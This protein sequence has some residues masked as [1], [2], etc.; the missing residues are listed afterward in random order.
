MFGKQLNG[1]CQLTLLSVILIVTSAGFAAVEVKTEHMNPADS[2][3]NFKTIVG[4]SKSDIASDA[5]FWIVENQLA[6]QG[7]KPEALSD[8]ELPTN[9]DHLAEIVFL[10][11]DSPDKGKILIDLGQAQKVSAFCTYSWHEYAPDDGSRGPQVYTLYGSKDDADHADPAKW[12]KIA[13]VDTRPNTTGEKWNGQYG[14][15]IKGQLGSYRYLLMV[16]SPTASPKQ[17]NKQ[18]TQTLF[19]EIDVHTDE[20]LAKAGDAKALKLVKVTDVYVVFK[21]HLDIGYTH[22]VEDVIKKYRVD[23][24]DNALK[25]IES[26]RSLPKN[27]RFAWTLPGWAT[28]AILGPE[29]DPERKKRIE[30]AIKNGEIAFHALPATLYTESLDYEDLVRGLKYSVDVAK[31]YDIPVTIAGKMTDVP[32]H[33]WVLPTLLKHAGI[34]FMHIGCNYASSYPIL[35]KLFWWEG[36]DGSR[37]LTAYTTGY[38]SGIIPPADWPAKNYLA[39]AMTNDNTGPPS[40]AD[41]ENIR[42]QAARDLPGVNIHFGTLDDFA[43]A[44][45]KEQPELEVV[46]GDTPDTWAHGL[47]SMPIATKLIRNTRPLG[48]AL[49][50]IDTQLNAWGVETDSIAEKQE[51]AYEQS[52][53]YSEHTWGMNGAYGGRDIW[54][55]QEVKKT[56]S[57]HKLEHFLKSFDDH[58]AYAQQ[59]GTIWSHEVSQRLSLLADSVKADGNSMVVY[60]A[61]PWKRS[62][63]V[64]IPGQNGGQMF[65]KDIPA[66]GYKTVSLD[67][68][69][70]TEFS[71]KNTLETPF[72]TVKFDLDRGGISSLKYKKTGRELVDTNS[73]YALGQFMHE[74]FSADNVMDFLNSY[75]RWEAGFGED[76]FGK[77][78][79]PKDIKYAKIVPSDWTITTVKSDSRDIVTLT[80]G[81]TKGLAKAY[82][83]T[84]SFSRNEPSVE[85]KWTVDT[86]TPKKTP[87]GGWLCMPLALDAPEFTVGRSGGPI[88]PSKDIIPG[89][90]RNLLTVMSGVSVQGADGTGMGVCPL[91]SPLVSLGIPGLYQYSLDY[92]PTEPVVFVNL[93]NN[94]WNTNFPLWIEG[95]WSERVKI[96]PITNKNVTEDLAVKSWESRM[97]LLAAKATGNKGMLPKSRRGLSLSRKGVL[98]TA[99][100]KDP[101]G[102]EGTL[103]R[104]W[105]QAGKSGKITVTLPKGIKVSKATAVN[106]RGESTGK[107]I[108]VSGGKLKFN[109]GAYAPA[110]YILQ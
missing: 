35:P 55:L 56:L 83:L 64:D 94:E 110:S 74:R 15:V 48:P 98:V 12:T 14:A 31:E 25:I 37:V 44:V 39:M 57:K 77:R 96:W 8:G 32:E 66:C 78:G 95:S 24:M 109:L 6:T 61:L 11:N 51:T 107:T 84:F 108:K 99:F 3:W 16:I 100:G 86:N 9:T 80:T 54:D 70:E 30:E 71:D 79:M 90:G 92:I 19:A 85:V 29:Q 76:D 65:V 5:Q 21:T 52:L 89:S 106:L 47:K 63:L 102:E 53:L 75:I 38:G 33:S 34:E 41:V 103:L 104:V 26:G 68:Y 88:D 72:Y 42:K 69:N 49:D 20:T 18:W 4:P 17:A 7:A 36:P 101:Y 91:D 10:H 28:S 43:R 81:E 59:A 105:E 22:L 23:M 46:R 58:R 73:E 2:R 27:Q 67:V 62:G 45:L 50:I 60:N 93:Y 40:P 87:E 1:K 13:D 97:P 82:R